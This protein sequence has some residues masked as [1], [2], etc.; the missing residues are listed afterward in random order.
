M[1]QRL[2]TEFKSEMLIFSGNRVFDRFEAVSKTEN[3]L[4]GNASWLSFDY[5]FYYYGY[6]P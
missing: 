5:G 6:F 4:A 2:L 1:H 3:N